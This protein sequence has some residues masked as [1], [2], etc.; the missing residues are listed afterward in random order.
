M[1][2]YLEVLKKYAVFDGRARR[3]E[4]WMFVLF[5]IIISIAIGMLFAL[6][7]LSKVGQVI[8]NL[9]QLAVLLPGIGVAIRRMHDADHSGWWLLVPIVNLVFA[10]TEGTRGP[11]RFG[12]DPKSADQVA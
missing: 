8:M 9:Y 5:N 4:Y 11:N 12:P 2:W 10:C 3:T 1:N 7:G 6:I